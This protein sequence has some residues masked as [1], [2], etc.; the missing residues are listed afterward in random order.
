MLSTSRMEIVLS[1]YFLLRRYFK[2]AFDVGT[3]IAHGDNRCV[4]LK[5]SFFSIL[6][7]KLNLKR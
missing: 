5:F 7:L 1:S 2:V 6:I 4:I 3:D